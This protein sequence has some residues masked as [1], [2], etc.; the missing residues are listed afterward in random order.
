MARRIRSL[1]CCSGRWKWGAKRLERATRSTIPSEQ[2]I[3]SSEPIRNRMSPETCSSSACRRVSRST[4]SAE[5]AAVRSEVDAGQ[6]D[7]LEPGG[8][9]AIDFGEDGVDRPAAR[10]ASRGRDDAVRA[11]LVAARL[12]TERA[13]GPSREHRAPARRRTPPRHNQ[14][15]SAVMRPRSDTSVIL[16]LVA[17]DLDH[18]GQR[19]RPR[20][21]TWWRSSRSPRSSRPDWLWLCVELPGGLAD[22]PLP[23]PSRC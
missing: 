7:F 17:D 9:D 13:G 12:H 16:P 6:R 14:S 4:G 23:S 18:A 19:G 11:L 20:P 8:R 15:A 22:R 5:I 10:G 1:A 3:G 21:C 2:S